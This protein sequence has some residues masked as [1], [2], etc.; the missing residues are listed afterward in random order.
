[1]LFIFICIYIYIYIYNAGERPQT[2][3][4]DGKKEDPQ[5]HLATKNIKEKEPERYAKDTWK[6]RK[7][8]GDA[9]DHGGPREA[10]GGNRRQHG[11]RQ[12]RATGGN[13]GQLLRIEFCFNA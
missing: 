1:M 4:V 11:G 12:L 3:L 5:K 7:T 9:G 2:K 6:R 8:T 10:T 13:K